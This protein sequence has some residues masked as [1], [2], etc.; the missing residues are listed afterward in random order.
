MLQSIRSQIVLLALVVAVP[1]VAAIAWFSWREY[2]VQREAQGQALLQLA[3]ALSSAVDRELA[4]GRTLLET[5]AGLPSLRPGQ[6]KEFHAQ[7]K[8]ALETRPHAWIVLWNRSGQQLLNTQRPWGEPLHNIFKMAPPAPGPEE[9]PTG[10]RWTVQ[11]V[12][13]A[14]QPVYSDL[15]MGVVS[16]R[17]TLT[18]DV[19]V[20]GGGGVVAYV[21]SLGLATDSFQAIIAEQK[22]PPDIGA[23]ITDR[24]HFAIARAVEPQKYVGKRVTAPLR[25][26]IERSAEEWGEGRTHEGKPVLHAFNTSETTGWTAAVS[27]TEAAVAMVPF[28]RSMGQWGLVLLVLVSF[29][30]LVTWWLGRRITAPILALAR[31]AQSMQ[32]GGPLELPVVHTRELAQLCA[33]LEASSVALRER[34]EERV[35]RI[36]AEARSR[37]AAEAS[38]AKDEFLAMLSHELRNPMAAIVFACELLGR[39][40]AGEAKSVQ[41]RESIKRQIARLRRLI[42]DLLDVASATHGKLQLQPGALELLGAARTAAGQARQ[43]HPSGAAIDVSGVPVT[44]RADAARVEQMIGNLLDNAAKSGASAIRV[45]VGEGS[46]WGVLTVA[47]DGAGIPPELLPRILEPVVQEP[48]DGPARTRGGL[49]LGLTLVSRL[50]ALHGGSLVA[51][52]E[53][54]GKGSAFTLRLPL[55]AGAAKAAPRLIEVALPRLRFLLVDDEPDMR[56]GLRDVLESDRQ[57]VAVA[58]DGAQALALFE[59]FDPQV[60][61][62]DIGLPGIDGYEVARRARAL[63]GGRTVILAALT[64]Y[65]Q[66][67]DR[68]RALQAGFD[69]HLTKPVS[70]EELKLSLMTFHP[71]AKPAEDLPPA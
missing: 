50:A 8:Q 64:G 1:L 63:D 51:R 54:P 9:L 47:D 44:V 66:D 30:A 32:R 10:N 36:E 41:A 56:D 70:Y 34:E 27:R 59:T 2:H 16:K 18:I 11:R 25:E 31:S 61:L 57:E 40:P 48:P 60:A 4:S 38:R 29:A 58:A 21:L 5:L 14:G 24:R 3:R 35:R 67:R 23:G 69:L 37:E 7:A 13:E 22:F 19:P 39:V 55:A 49:G 45:T 42:E 6:Y 33:A 62:V 68:E 52:S 20:M 53:G 17:P 28:W 43:R 65:G 46:Q 26:A 12:L 15:F 71:R